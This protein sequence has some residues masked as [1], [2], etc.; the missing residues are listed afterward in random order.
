MD[1]ALS[2]H[3]FQFAFTITY[4]YLFPQLTMGLALLIVIL[5]GLAL[6]TGKKIERRTPEFHRQCD[7]R[8]SAADDADVEDAPAIVRDDSSI[9]KHAPRQYQLACLDSENIRPC[10]SYT[11]CAGS[12][13]WTRCVDIV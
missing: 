3:R 10:A 12:A 13:I 4:H 1:T 2:A 5:K 11:S 7:A 9:E 6:R 8:H